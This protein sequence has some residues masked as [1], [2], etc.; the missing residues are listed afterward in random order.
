LPQAGEPTP[1]PPPAS[2]AP[3]AAFALERFTPGTF[4]PKSAYEHWTR[5]LLATRYV[6]GRDVVDYGCGTG[7]GARWLAESARDVLAVDVSEEAIAYARIAYPHP[8]VRYERCAPL[9]GEVPDASADVVVCFEVIEH[10]LPQDELL[11]EFRRI[12]RPD[13]VVL[14]STPDPSYT[15]TLGDN[16][17]HVRELARAELEALVGR[18][19]AERHV[20]VQTLAIGEALTPDAPGQPDEV[21]GGVRVLRFDPAGNRWHPD[22]GMPGAVESY[23]VVASNR[24]LP[25]AGACVVADRD[26]RLLADLQAYVERL[27]AERAGLVVAQRDA[28]EGA[29]AARERAWGLEQA[30]GQSEA[31][32]AEAAQALAAEQAA[33]GAAEARLATTEA[34]L[35]E[36]TG[37]LGAARAALVQSESD[38]RRLRL[39]VIYLERKVGLRWL[40]WAARGGAR[41]L[42][43]LLSS[44]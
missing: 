39:D 2:D 19:F 27:E 1:A 31:M 29:Q 3:S 30:L 25:P 36:T 14:L 22:A 5:Y 28:A 44:R 32:R 42:R 34:A 23:V 8:R 18:H 17:F 35:A 10:L 40:S 12:L 38:V 13:G 37:T 20:F 11:A 7:Y 15:V 6:A 26:G 16:P 9:P 21:A 33:R 41:R 4:G 24:P 43:R